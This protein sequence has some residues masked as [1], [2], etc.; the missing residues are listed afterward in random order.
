MKTVAVVG[1]STHRQKYGNKCVR[2]YASAGWQ[3]YPVNPR[4]DEVEGLE[5]FPDLGGLP[6]SPDLISVYLPPRRTL[7]LLD[8]IAAV[9]AGETIFNPGS[10]D[11]EVIRKAAE[12][13][14]PARQTCSIVDIGLSPAEFP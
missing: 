1:A 4:G 11:A 6:Q 3:V 14:I 10:A 7:G 12:L 2:A 9:G 13:R 5:V 8:E